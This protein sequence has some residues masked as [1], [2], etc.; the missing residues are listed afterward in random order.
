M[1]STKI[2][3]ILG[4]PVAAAAAANGNNNPSAKASNPAGMNLAKKICGF[5]GWLGLL[6]P[7][8]PTKLQPR[9]SSVAMITATNL[10]L[11]TKFFR[12][13][14]VLQTSRSTL[15]DWKFT[16]CSHAAPGPEGTTAL[17]IRIWKT[18]E[19]LL[20]SSLWPIASCETIRLGWEQ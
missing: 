10:G 17:R 18:D 19:T 4:R 14:A 9:P 7:Q 5:I 15:F 2:T 12:S 13:A 3:M 20:L 1:S 11:F 6:T 16:D 8:L